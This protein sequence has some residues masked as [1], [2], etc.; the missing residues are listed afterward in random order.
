M[1]HRDA[2]ECR[3]PLLQYDLSSKENNIVTIMPIELREIIADYAKDDIWT[4]EFFIRDKNFVSK[5]YKKK[6]THGLPFSL[7]QVLWIIKKSKNCKTL[8]D[9]SSLRKDAMEGNSGANLWNDKAASRLWSGESIL[10]C[11]MQG[12]FDD[13]SEDSNTQAKKLFNALTLYLAPKPKMMDREQV[14]K[15]KFKVLLS[16]QKI[17]ELIVG[18]YYTR[19][20]FLHDAFLEERR[21]RDKVNKSV[22]Y[23]ATSGLCCC[24][25]CTISGSSVLSVVGCVFAQPLLAICGSLIA[26]LTPAISV[27][28][29]IKAGDW[30][31]NN[32]NDICKIAMKKPNTAPYIVNAQKELREKKSIL[33]NSQILLFDNQF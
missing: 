30:L 14:K 10:K 22:L 13:Y 31:I 2:E 27:A 26:I 9:I 5:K 21:Y 15:N 29:S 17:K 33:Q 16:S 1:Q 23:A 28:I 12:V 19:T 11:D 7:Y 3:T 4:L 8:K 24:T 18:Y 25:A 20:I 6:L 32:N